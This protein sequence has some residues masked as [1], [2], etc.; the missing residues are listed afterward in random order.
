M[1]DPA[2]NFVYEVHVYPDDRQGGG[3]NSCSDVQSGVTQL[4]PFVTWMRGLSHPA[5]AFLGEFSAGVDNG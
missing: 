5:K 2:N 1:T 4:Q 3:S